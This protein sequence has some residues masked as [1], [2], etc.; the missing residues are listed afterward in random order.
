M[1][2]GSPSAA[3]TVSS[4]GARR[5][6]R[7]AAIRSICSGVNPES[8]IQ[9]WITSPPA[10]APGARQTS[11]QPIGRLPRSRTHPAAVVTN[12]AYSP[13][14]MANASSPPMCTYGPGDSA[15]SISIASRAKR[16]AAGTPGRRCPSQRCTGGSGPSSSG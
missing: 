1:R 12:S 13:A 8:P 10:N 5:N 15:H 4:S 6:G 3:R 9:A 14:S 2:A 11:C 7:T 16:I